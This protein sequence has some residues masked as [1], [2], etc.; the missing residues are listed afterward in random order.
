MTGGDEPG[1]EKIQALTSTTTKQ[2]DDV[3]EGKINSLDEAEIFL[4]EHDIS[5][6]RLQEMMNDEAKAKKL[7]R[8]IDCT[9]LPLLCGTYVLQY[10]D[11]QV[12]FCFIFFSVIF[13]LKH[14]LIKKA[15]SYSAVFDLFSSA[16]ITSDQYGWLVSIFYFG[17]FLPSSQ[18]YTD[19]Y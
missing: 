1:D 19:Q 6:A 12:R 8:R 14:W 3:E 9:L 2:G 4:Y 7:R 16:N 11:K 15:L 13:F 17:I 5:H 18:A 10:I